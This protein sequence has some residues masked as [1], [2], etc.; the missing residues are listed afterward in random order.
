M[1]L[2]TNGKGAIELVGSGQYGRRHFIGSCIVATRTCIQN[3]VQR[4]WINSRFHCHGEPFKNS[5]TAS[6][7]NMIVDELRYLLSARLLA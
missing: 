6:S 3:V 5:Q 4:L 1:V 7:G 2:Q